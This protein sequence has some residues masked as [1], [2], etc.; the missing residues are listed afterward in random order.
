[1]VSMSVTM[2][3]PSPAARPTMAKFFISSQP[4]APAPTWNH[5]HFVQYKF[6]TTVGRKKPTPAEQ[7]QQRRCE[8]QKQTRARAHS[9]GSNAACQAAPA[10]L[11]QKLQFAH[12]NGSSSEK[13]RL[14]K[15]TGVTQLFMI[16]TLIHLLSAAL[17]SAAIANSHLQGCI[18]PLS[19]WRHPLQPGTPGH[20]STTTAWWAWI[21]QC[22]PTERNESWRGIKG[23][24][25]L[26]V[27]VSTPT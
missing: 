15:E 23:N 2:T 8:T 24:T 19:A 22:T 5:K 26:S 11:S 14:K 6:I 4:M 1:M 7:W 9:P 17:T 21:F 27:T 18:P 12:R 16:M 10:A 3:S 20:R 25:W 13:R